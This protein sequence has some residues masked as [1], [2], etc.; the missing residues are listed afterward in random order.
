MSLTLWNEDY[1]HDR[2]SKHKKILPGQG[3]CKI[4][5]KLQY[6]ATA[7]ILIELLLTW[8]LSIRYF[9]FHKNV[10]KFLY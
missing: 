10:L 1:D 6:Y 2:E 5:T 4:A 7:V 9:S 8:Y 3:F